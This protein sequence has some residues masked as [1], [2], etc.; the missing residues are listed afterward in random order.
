MDTTNSSKP[1]LDRILAIQE[2]NIKGKT[3]D[4][5]SINDYYKAASRGAKPIQYQHGLSNYSNVQLGDDRVSFKKSLSQDA[6]SLDIEQEEPPEE[7]GNQ[8]SYV[9]AKNYKQRREDYAEA[10]DVVGLNKI[11]EMEQMM[12]DKLQ[13]RTKTGPFQLRKTFKYFD[14][15]GSGGIDFS[16][17]QRAMELMG[18]QFTEIQQLALFA[19]YDESCTGEVDYNDFVVK[20]MESDFKV[21]PKDA[22]KKNLDSMISSTF[23]S[24]ESLLNLRGEQLSNDDDM[25]DADEE[26]LEQLRRREV[27]KMFDLIDKDGSGYIDRKELETLLKSLNKTFTHDEVNEGFAR[28]D[29][30]LSGRIDFDEFYGWYKNENS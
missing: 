27:K 22:M 14:R 1:R 9:Q 29:V 2:M 3:K 21:V 20:V 18:F 23:S 30:D 19:R 17:F 4:Y 24:G 16:E 6:Y 13:Q 28:V 15:D 7:K 5:P 26:E 11:H 8:G 12:R 10:N 25:S